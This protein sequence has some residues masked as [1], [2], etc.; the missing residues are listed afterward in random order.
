[1][2]ET[3]KKKEHYVY[4]YVDPRNE[5]VFYV[6]CGK[7]KR[8]F[9]HLLPSK[10]KVKSEKT[11]LI[12][13]IFDSGFYPTI[14]VIEKDLTQTEALCRERFWISFYGKE[15]LT[16]KTS[17][18]QGCSGFPTFLGKHHTEE[19]KELIRKSKL[20]SKNPMFGKKRSVEA[21]KKFSEKISGKNHF[22]YGISRSEATKEKI[23]SKLKGYKW[24]EKDCLKRKE[25]M[26]KVW[27]ARKKTGLGMPLHSKRMIQ[28]GNKNLSIDNWSNL[29]GINKS[30]IIARIKRGLTSQQALEMEK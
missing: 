30:T 2:S 5:K 6:G 11:L 21:L 19:S 4:S 22:S 1:M 3:N 26:K 8:M 28:C 23:S 12:D 27:E 10:R 25:G 13:Q 14:T 9:A 20:G 17:G 16:N 24:S 15:N 18:G 29:T 7:N